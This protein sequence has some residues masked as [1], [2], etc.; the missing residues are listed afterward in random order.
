MLRIT[1]ELLSARTGKREILGV[2][3][4]VNKG[5]H[6]YGSTRGDYEGQLFRK[7]PFNGKT[8]TGNILTRGIVWDYPR[9]S[10]PV[11]RLLAKMLKSMYPEER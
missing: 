8:R 7:G 4:I 5:N 2:M 6:E 9:K 10:Y 11:W 1:I 3:E